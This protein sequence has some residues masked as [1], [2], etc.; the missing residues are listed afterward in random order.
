MSSSSLTDQALRFH[1]EGRFAEAE[2][3]YRQA[4]ADQPAGFAPRHFLGILKLQQGQA[5]EALALIGGALEADP[6]N[7]EAL[8]NYGNALKL[9]GRHE[10]ALAC[11]DRAL[12]CKPGAAGAPY[13]RAILFA[14]MGRSIEALENYGQAIALR[15]DFFE[16]LHERAL[17]LR[18][19]NRPEEALAD[20]DR[21]LKL[22]PEFAEGWSNRAVLLDEMNRLEEAL[23]S[24]EHALALEP[25][26]AEAL[27]NRG[28]VLTKLRRF[29]EALASFDEALAIKPLAYAK[30]WVN[31]GI[32]LKDMKRFPEAMESFSRALVID[33]RNAEALYNR[34]KIAWLEF[35]NYEAALRDL[36]Q[37]VAED[38]DLPYAQGFLMHVKMHGGDWRGRA[39]DIARVNAGV[40]AGAPVMEPF[41]YQ[42]LSESPQ[43]LQTCAVHYAARNH[44]ALTA[45]HGAKTRPGKI[46]IGYV[47]GEF[48][49]QATSYLAAG[50]YEC[51]DRSRFE[52]I[53]FD[54]G[55][56]DNSPLRRRLEQAFDGF[57]DV[58]RLS[59]A[60]AAL[61]IVREEIDIL[62]N[63]NG[64][65]G[66]RRMGIFAR[67]PAPI[68][69]N[70]L[71]FPGTLGAP[72]MDYI[73]ADAV[74][75]PE[76]E[77]RFYNEKV[78]RLPFS[79]QVNDSKRPIA[80]AAPARADCGLPENGTVF[81]SFNQSYKLAPEMF[82]RW[83]AILRRTPD[84]VLWL[85]EGHRVFADNLR[86]EAEARGVKGE[87]I[88]FAPMIRNEKHLARLRLADLFLDTLP[89]NAHTTASDA[90]WA[91]VPLLTCRGTTFPGRVAASLLRA[92]GLPE[93]VTENLDAYEAMAVELAGDPVLLGG[94][95]EKL[96]ENRLPAPLFDT[97]RYCRHLEEAY[98]IMLENWRSGQPP[99]AFAVPPTVC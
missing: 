48:Y 57:I 15:P 9:L 34:G 72:Y 8:I 22:R 70:F 83:M 24:C 14:D 88:L 38:P 71:G 11:F 97:A 35:R 64:Y 75:I 18:N 77:E 59:D 29:D 31:R 54:N 76:Q 47:S 16:A 21:L 26:Q 90:L 82:E 56:N 84:S 65:F 53:A 37:A 28:S 93:L 91:G 87:R 92:V 80:E 45:M 5:E 17:L 98:R 63:L 55:P 3:L 25:R 73:V 99:Q 68:Q 78:A 2:R 40:R 79:Y 39:A 86:R 66:E 58:S 44:P 96:R 36:Q 20:F 27:H 67:K 1:Q 43:D 50:L 89:Y 94:L 13:N 85:L 23:T 69:V 81:C 32:L 62:V 42:A 12:E 7:A 4:L 19:L 60:A 33:P 30:A 10:E 74:V 49:E 51:H 41:T 95:R 46:R 6:K 52:I 61:R